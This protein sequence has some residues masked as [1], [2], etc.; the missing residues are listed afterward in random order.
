MDSISAHFNINLVSVKQKQTAGTP[1]MYGRIPEFSDAS[2]SYCGMGKRGKLQKN[3]RENRVNVGGG[4]RAC[5]RNCSLI[6]RKKLHEFQ[7]H[8][9]FIVRAS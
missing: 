7:I 9:S 1:V 4:N 6:S 2:T 8:F 3:R 5:V